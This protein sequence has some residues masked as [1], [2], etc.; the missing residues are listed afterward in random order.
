M[1]TRSDARPN[2][3]M[4]VS[5]TFRRD[6][7]SAYGQRD[8]DTPSL[9]RL[10]GTSM[11]FDRAYCNSFP[12][13][14]ARADLLTGRYTFTYR[15]W[16]PLGADEIT[17]PQIFAEHGYTTMGVVDTPFFVREAY[18]F[19][20][21]FGDFIA[22]RGS[23]A[24]MPDGRDTRLT[25]VFETDYAA[26]AT[27][28]EAERWLQR[29]HDERFFLYVDTWDPHEPWDPPIWYTRR[30]APDY[31][32]RPIAPAYGPF[33][34][35]GMTE[36]DVEAGY[37]AYRGE[38]TMVDRWIGR[39]LDTL[40]VLG[41]ADDTIV[42][43]VSDHGYYF[44][45]HGFYGKS[46]MGDLPFGALAPNPAKAE[47]NFLRSPLYEEVAHV[48][49][50]VRVPGMPAGR[51]SALVSHA[52]VMPSLLDLAGLPIPDTVDGHSFRSAIAGT[53]QVANDMV[54]SSW[55]LYNVG[56]VSR[57]VDSFERTI[58]EPL[59][60][61]I[62]SGT[63][64]LLYTVEGVPVELYDLAADPEQRVDVAA[65][66]PDVVRDLHRRFVERLELAGTEERLLAPRRRIERA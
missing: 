49:L 64:Q 63:W 31:D 1:T 35:K 16:M 7:L 50:L 51:T 22:I 28:F 47:M 21:G 23:H 10:A 26:P 20:K 30:Y 57:A 13:M 40:D 36:A 5:D 55:P 9:D 11:I 3:L 4:I 12:T 53:D 34:D 29:H 33:A 44:G 45:E 52:D 6:N 62:T 65:D 37:A 14:P 46:V 60:S 38:V 42:V 56:E 24:Q 43:F 54:I 59:P 25:R 48:P 18:G 19:D 27:M 66:H 17:L 58:R 15:G 8:V 61:T 32:G 41:L 39:L 2:V